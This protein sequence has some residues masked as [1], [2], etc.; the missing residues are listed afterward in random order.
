[1]SFTTPRPHSLKFAVFTKTLHLRR[2]NNQA[3][4]F[5]S[6]GSNWWADK[7]VMVGGVI[8]SVL[9]FNKLMFHLPFNRS[10][11]KY[12]ENSQLYLEKKNL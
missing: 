12:R 6:S 8:K 1:M 10:L 2:Y 4:F 11:V 7:S 9:R 5:L 3:T